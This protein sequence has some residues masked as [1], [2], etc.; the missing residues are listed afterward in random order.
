MTKLNDFQ[1]FKRLL[2]YYVSHIEY[3]QNQD[4]SFPGY[5]KYIKALDQK[6][7]FNYTGDDV[8]YQLD[9]NNFDSDFVYYIRIKHNFGE[10]TS[11][12]CY[13]QISDE[14]YNIVSYWENG[15]VSK[16]Q[17]QL[18]DVKYNDRSKAENKN[19][20][21]WERVGD[22]PLSNW[23]SIS[24]LGLFDGKEP[25][26]ILKNFFI[27]LFEEP[28]PDIYS[29]LK[30]LYSMEF[31]M[32]EIEKAYSIIKNKKNLILQGAPGTGKTYS[33][34]ELATAICNG[35]D[36]IKNKTREDIKNEYDKLVKEGRIAFCTFHQSM[37]YEDFI[38]GMKPNLLPGMSSP[39]YIIE[40]GLF[41]IICER[42]NLSKKTTIDNF[43]EV[44]NK[45][46][47]YFEENRFIDVTIG[48]GDNQRQMH[49][50]LNENGD[51]LT[52]R[53]YNSEKDKEQGNWIQGKS[54]FFNKNQLYNVYRGMPGTPSGGHDNYRKAIVEHLKNNFGLK[55]YDESANKN[56]ELPFVLIIDEINRGNI[57]KIFG[58]LITLLETD[59][60]IGQDNEILVSLPYSKGKKLLDGHSTDVTE[61]FGVPSNLY[62]IGTMNTT[63]RST[64]TLDYAL[65]RRFDFFTIKAK[66]AVIT[67]YDKF[68]S[69]ETK[70]KALTLFNKVQNFIKNKN[71]DDA[72]LEDLFLGHSY[73]LAK[74]ENELESKLKYEIEPLIKEYIKD[75]I[76]SC[77]KE[78]LANEFLNW[79]D[80]NAELDTQDSIDDQEE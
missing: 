75:G 4:K 22:T 14:A 57:S 70:T 44:F 51:G 10:Y 19:K 65:R 76:L 7:K 8:K 16:L 12:K 17:Y 25:N 78:N 52:E 45:L 1:R 23:I 38:E 59:K 80:F 53:T 2:E 77:S 18:V 55:P 54:K 58:E 24:E 68:D 61:L 41:K 72:D 71:I 67:N 56:E 20:H 6:Q 31:Q 66:A 13:I 64:G 11:K 27:N 33:T 37:D 15:H 46:I 40:N 79:E 42:A 49:V 29:K 9:D 36:S 39:E 48:K 60:R 43:N 5:Q 32:E 50:E 62:I 30:S 35:F 26:S 63:D 28:Y 47:E 34:V 74:D 69:E 73:F 3:T 21:E